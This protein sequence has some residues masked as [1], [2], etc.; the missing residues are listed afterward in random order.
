[1][2][3][4]SKQ[5]MIQEFKH[6]FVLPSDSNDIISMFWTKLALEKVL[7]SCK[8]N[9]KPSTLADTSMNFF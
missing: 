4:D 9:D 1:M 2:D 6:A 3:Y 8:S 7:F 5:S